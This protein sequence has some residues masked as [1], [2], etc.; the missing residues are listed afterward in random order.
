M[1]YQNYIIHY[2]KNHSSKNGQF[3]SGDGDGDGIANDHANRRKEPTHRGTKSMN[4]KSKKYIGSGATMFGAG[5]TMIAASE[6][7]RSFASKKLAKDGKEL[8]VANNILLRGTEA[9]GT[10]LSIYGAVKLASGI[11]LNIKSN[12]DLNR[13]KKENNHD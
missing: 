7:V 11:G 13:M 12:A 5:S 3:V 1:Y 8:S 4:T 10:F 6:M 2:N 9:A